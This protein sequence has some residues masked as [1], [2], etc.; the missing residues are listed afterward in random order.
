MTKNEEFNLF[1][2]EMAEYTI[3]FVVLIII[4]V[5]GCI[6]IYYFFTTKK[7]SQTFLVCDPG[8]CS[9]NVY[10]GEKK[11]SS[12]D[13]E[14]IVYDPAFEVCNSKYTCN[15]SRTPYALNSDGST[16]NLGVC[17]NDTICRC[18]KSARC[19]TDVVSVF[20]KENSS[21]VQNS[22]EIQG[23]NGSQFFDIQDPF[24]TFC[25][26]KPN[27]LD[28]IGPGSCNFSDNKKISV[29]EIE[30]CIKSNPC[31]IG[32]LAFFPNDSDNF[33]LNS[34]NKNSIYNVP[35]ACVA[36]KNS[37]NGKNLQNYCPQKTVPV[38]NKKLRLVECKTTLGD[39][40]TESEK[41]N[42]KIQNTNDRFKKMF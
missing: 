35:V 21:F 3:I 24:T 15:S 41:I 28:K 6:T 19:S 42:D 7:N 13:K 25:A 33:V 10:N 14:K 37:V 30:I 4:F 40:K 39:P 2:T 34:Q 5:V 23:S 22:L 8:E 20:K 12:N 9:T 18:L 26:I 32:M 27:N 38:W 36:T 11:C 1:S 31:H 16:N 17:Q 29:D